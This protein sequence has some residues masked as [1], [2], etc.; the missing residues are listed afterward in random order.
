MATIGA[1]IRIISAVTC[2]AISAALTLLFLGLL[3]ASNFGFFVVGSLVSFVLALASSVLFY[4]SPARIWSRAL[5][6]LSGV[7]AAFWGFELVQIAVEWKH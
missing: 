2:L 5:S 6:I 3:G 4:L 7:L 1:A